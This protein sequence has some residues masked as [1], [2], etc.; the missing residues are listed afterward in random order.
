MHEHFKFQ[1]FFKDS[2]SFQDCVSLAYCMMIPF[3]IKMVCAL[4]LQIKNSY[5]E[6]ISFIRGCS[7][8]IIPEQTFEDNVFKFCVSNVTLAMIEGTLLWA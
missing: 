4:I 5:S 3:Q 2:R 1:D 7:I 6:I 8:W